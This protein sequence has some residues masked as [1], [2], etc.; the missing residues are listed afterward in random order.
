MSIESFQVFTSQIDRGGRIT[1]LVDTMN[2]T[3][4]LFR[5][6][7]A[8]DKVDKFKDHF[9]ILLK[10][11]I[12]CAYFV[13]SYAKDS[14]G[15]TL[16]AYLNSN[17]TLL[18]SATQAI[19]GVLSAADSA[20]DSYKKT[21]TDLRSDFETDATLKTA[22]VVHKMAEDVGEMKV[23]IHNIGVHIIAGLDSI[24]TRNC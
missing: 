18:P 5:L 20:I 16:I 6:N 22:T 4:E 13:Q 14:F 19:K 10:Q 9:D 21:F 11:T 15:E 17:L 7:E 2:K 24:L 3:Y 23:G 12:E 1:E 8:L